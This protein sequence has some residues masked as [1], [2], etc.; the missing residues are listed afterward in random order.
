LSLLFALFS[1]VVVSVLAETRYLQELADLWGIDG[2][3]LAFTS[4][5]LPNLA[6]LI[7][8][9]VLVGRGTRSTRYANR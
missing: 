1:G 6:W 7:G 2:E 5:L 4:W 8:Y 9:F 3:L